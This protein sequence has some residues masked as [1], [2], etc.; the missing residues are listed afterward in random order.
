MPRPIKPVTGGK[1]YT[2]ASF[3]VEAMVSSKGAV[4]G[5]RVQFFDANKLPIPEGI[6]PRVAGI[7]AGQEKT[8]AQAIAA[9]QANAGETGAAW[10]LR[11]AAPYVALVYG[12]TPA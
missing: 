2:A 4:H 8:A 10:L 12:I 6:V 5:L 1:T 11:A 7:T 3:E 9:V